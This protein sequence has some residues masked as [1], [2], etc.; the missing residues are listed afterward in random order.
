MKNKNSPVSFTNFQHHRCNVLFV[1][2]TA[3]IH[4]RKDVKEFLDRSTASNE[5]V[6][7]VK[8]D[9]EDDILMA[10]VE[11]LAIFHNV[12]TATNHALVLRNKPGQHILDLNPNLLRKQKF[13]EVLSSEPSCVL[14]PGYQLWNGRAANLTVMNTDHIDV[15]LEVLSLISTHTLVIFTRLAQNQLPTGIHSEDSA[16]LR[17]ESESV[18]TSNSIGESQFAVLKH[19]R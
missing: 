11:G 3:L 6:Q 13:L 15:V 19:L 7:C 16:S 8:D 4:H 5:L 17:S 2:A 1:N 10:C 18:P 14:Q 12:V 9:L